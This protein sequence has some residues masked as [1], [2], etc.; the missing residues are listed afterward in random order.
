MADPE[1]L[2]AEATTAWR[3]RSPSGR[4]LEHPA[5]ADLDAAARQRVFEDT[6]VMRVLEAALDPDGYSCTVR[7]VAAAIATR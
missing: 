3:P 2:V 4:I 5:W 7:A 6:L 1:T